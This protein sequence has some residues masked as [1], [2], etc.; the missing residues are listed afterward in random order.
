MV[1][2]GLVVLALRAFAGGSG[3]NTFVVVN[4]NSTNSVELGNYYCER[5]GVPAQNLLRINWPGG[6]TT[7][8]RS[9]FESALRAPLLNALADRR[10]TNQIEY[11]VLC[12]DLPYQVT[13]TTGNPVTSGVNSTTSVLFYGF[14]PDGCINCPGGLPSC[15]LPTETTNRYAGSEGIF[16]HTP[17]INPN[18]NSWLAFLLTAPDLARAKAV[19]DLGV[20][21]DGSLPTQPVFLT[22]S[23]DKIRNLR[24]LQADDVVFNTRID[25]N[26]PIVQ[27]NTSSPL[28]LGA[29][30]GLQIGKQVFTVTDLEAAP[31]AMIDNLTSYGGILFNYTEHTTAMDFIRHGATA[32]YGT[33]VEPCAYAEKFPAA[34][35]YF[36]QVRGFS[37]AEGYYQS[38]T[39]PY[40]GVLVGEPLAAP[41]ALPG[42]GSWIG[43]PDEAPLHGTTNLTLH[44]ESPTWA[45]PFQ[46]VDLFVD[47]NWFT[48]VSNL[49][50]Q[51]GNRLSTT[52]NN[53]PVHYE[54]P[55]E[56]TIQSV[57]TGLVAQLNAV[58]NSTK[59]RAVA[60][61]DRVE[62]QSL[63][64]NASGSNVTISVGSAQKV[65]EPLTTFIRASRST[66]LDTA[67]VGLLQF[68]VM[69]QVVE[70][71]YLGLTVTLTNGATTTITLTN[72]APPSGN[73][74]TDL[75]TLVQNLIT[76]IN[77]HPALTGLDGVQAEDLVVMMNG[78]IPYAQFNL[79]ARHHG[80]PAAQIQAQLLGTFTLHPE[81]SKRLEDNL[82]DLRPRNHLYLTAGLTNWNLIVPLNTQPLPDGSHELLAVAY[83][84]SHVR[85]QTRATQNIR[86]TNNDW[87]ATLTPLLGG[88]TT[89]VEA[90]LQF[91][92]EVNT[93][94]VAM[95][96]LFSTG[97][98]LGVA[99]N[100]NQ[101]TFSVAAVDLGIGLHPIHALVTRTDGTQ[102]RTETF[103]TR[104]VGREM[105]FTLTVTE[106]FPTITWPAAAGRT[107]QILITTNL[108]QPF[109]AL[110]T[111]IPTNALGQWFDA[112]VLNQQRFYL[113]KTP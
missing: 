91:L 61:G 70:E 86:V 2:L 56:A 66:F 41:F 103:W 60:H 20:A 68:E 73:P 28:G 100:S 21:A 93:N 112:A 62:L 14:H 81:T 80:W 31:G 45:R 9:E 29:M 106:P 16:R 48:T 27:T 10:L 30:S 98:S 107:Y 37:I 12:M 24:Y 88:S 65:E 18:S 71:D 59:V 26:R 95:I 1:I 67:A 46:Q 99:Q 104:I 64:L 72:Q 40:Q 87:M 23:S 74:V 4:Q 11:L 108:T 89:A 50:P 34:Q 53:T 54:V 96:E 101:A 15:N 78:N 47:G 13:E 52:I 22:K 8:T 109:A 49:L 5:R 7:W 102:F 17:P 75:Q 38:V 55:P 79:R 111:V 57:V 94:E 83:E 82:N 77:T 33:I 69:G 92:V 84:G 19:V 3:L 42:S 58:T 85:T 25:G 76:G 90:T 51:V 105:P 39:N 6:N 113:V 63:N 43:L 36:Y 35:N 32:S 44:L 110:A 97:G